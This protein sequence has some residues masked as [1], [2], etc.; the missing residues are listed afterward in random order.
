MNEVER[1]E[2]G[3]SQSCVEVQE[4]LALRGKGLLPG[5]AETQLEQHLLECSPCADEAAL[6]SRLSLAIAEPPS[7]LGVRILARALRESKG[8]DIP[9]I[10]Q[11][12]AGGAF[13]GWRSWAAAAAILLAVFTGMSGPGWFFGAGSV[14]DELNP[15]A[16]VDPDLDAW[17][18]DWF[19]AGAPVLEGLSD[20]TLHLLA[21]EMTP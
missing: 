19:V 5:P 3:V 7:D 17:A 12:Q 20:E 6:L 16:F 18:E 4:N 15:L 21:L 13:R 14:A 1:P 2:H 11:P 9:T 8:A 10:P